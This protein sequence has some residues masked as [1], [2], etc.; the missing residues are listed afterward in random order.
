MHSK[1]PDVVLKT[2]KTLSVERWTLF[3][4]SGR[5]GYVVEGEGPPRDDRGA[6]AGDHDHY[7][8]L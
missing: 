7:S 3:T 5:H 2:V 1:Y 6:N 4:L 8:N